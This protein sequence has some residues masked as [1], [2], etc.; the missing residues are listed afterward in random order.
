MDGQVVRAFR[1]QRHR[2]QILE[3]PLSSGSSPVSVVRGLLR[4]ADFRAIYV[5]DLDALMGRSPQTAMVDDLLAAFPQ[6]QFWLDCGLPASN[7]TCE[8]VVSVIGSESMS[9]QTPERL[10]AIDQSYVLSLD[11]RGQELVGPQEI[12]NS[13]DWWPA[14]VILMNL[15]RVGSFDGPDLF[16]ASR[17][18]RQ[19]PGHDFIAAGGIRH[20]GDLENL[21]ET[22]VA[23]VLLASALHAGTI[24]RDVLSRFSL[25]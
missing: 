23:A 18:I 1:G 12:L 13:A 2:Y 17:F 22:G 11:F 14:R 10:A 21:R 9:E 25:E 6:I 3:S 16:G 4:L 8:R 5:A 24:D 20:E 19:Y 15:A 7:F